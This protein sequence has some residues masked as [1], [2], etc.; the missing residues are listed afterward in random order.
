VVFVGKNSIS[1]TIKTVLFLNVCHVM[2]LSR[3]VGWTSFRVEKRMDE[4][5]T[6]PP[7]NII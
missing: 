1:K 2:L 3:E 4:D 6:L 5:S 7:K